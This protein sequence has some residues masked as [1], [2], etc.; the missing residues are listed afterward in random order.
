VLLRSLGPARPTPTP[1]GFAAPVAEVPK[2]RPARLA[3][4]LT[5][6][7]RDFAVTRAMVRGFY[8]PLLEPGRLEEDLADPM[9]P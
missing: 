4:G 6:P 7:T 3:I 8:A 2:L 1:R 5:D 9:A